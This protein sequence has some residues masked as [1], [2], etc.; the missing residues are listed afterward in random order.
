MKK[1][2]ATLALV[3]GLIAVGI[4]LSFYGSY[5]TVKDLTQVD[6][7][8]G[9]GESLEITIELD[10]IINEIGVYAVQT[11]DINK[12]DISIQILDPSGSQIISKTIEMESFQEQ[13]DI[14]DKGNFRLVIENS[15]DSTEVIGAIGHLPDS[16]GNLI[17]ITGFF[18]LVVGL[19]GIVG[20]GIYVVKNRKRS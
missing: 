14:S 12:G 20:L 1:A 2:G 3:G 5:V 17:S 10:P 4:T 18:L 19:L 13:F 16:S 7:N 11:M 6:G 15:G 8:I 9:D